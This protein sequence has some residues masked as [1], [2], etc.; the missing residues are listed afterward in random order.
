MED[1]ESEGTT[2]GL[3]CV[4]G[5]EGVGWSVTGSD[6]SRSGLTEE[7]RKLAMP[8]VSLGT[9]MG[10]AGA[11]RGVGARPAGATAEAAPAARAPALAADRLGRRLMLLLGFLPRAIRQS[12]QFH[13]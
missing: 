4:S 5:G 9:M 3:G 11:T 1:E 10:R 7:P 12:S 6:L 13:T 8:E 2:G